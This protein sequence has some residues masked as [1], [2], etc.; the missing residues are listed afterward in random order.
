MMGRWSTGRSKEK[1]TWWAA[2]SRSADP[3][4]RGFTMISG[5]FGVDFGPLKN[6][7]AWSARCMQRPA[8]ARA[9]QG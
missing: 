3:R 7:Q 1:S 5:R 2:I 8:M 4:A 9:M 6:V